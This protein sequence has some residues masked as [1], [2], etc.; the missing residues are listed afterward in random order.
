MIIISP[1]KHLAMNNLFSFHPSGFS[2]SA[3]KKCCIASGSEADGGDANS[4]AAIFLS[5]HDNYK[6][7]VINDVLGVTEEL[8]LLLQSKLFMFTTTELSYESGCYCYCYHGQ[9]LSACP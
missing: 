1:M 2:L 4:V 8:L 7:I 6:H 3:C 5:I 9:H